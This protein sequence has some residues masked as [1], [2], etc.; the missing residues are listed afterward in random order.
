METICR[1]CNGER[2]YDDYHRIHKRCNKCN[3]RYSLN[4]YY[5]NKDKVSEKR[6]LYDKNKREKFFESNGNQNKSL[7]IF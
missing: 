5:A 2:Q 3:V 4:F 6:K 7:K 1:I